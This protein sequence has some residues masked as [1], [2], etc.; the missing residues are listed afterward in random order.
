MSKK[1]RK[2]R[3]D[4]M[5]LR[6]RL[7][8]WAQRFN[9]GS[10]IAWVGGVLY[11]LDSRT[12]VRGVGKVPKYAGSEAGGWDSA[13]PNVQHHPHSTSSYRSPSWW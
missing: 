5:S 2:K 1:S 6:K 8:K 9:P 13:F 7:K 3:G 4:F 10:K 12:P 11:F